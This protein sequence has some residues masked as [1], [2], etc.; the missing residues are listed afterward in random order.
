MPHGL[1]PVRGDVRVPG[2]DFVAGLPTAACWAAPRG[3]TLMRALVGLP[4]WYSLLRSHTDQRRL[5]HVANI[6]V[7]E[8]PRFCVQI[9]RG[10]S[11][12]AT[13]KPRTFYIS[14]FEPHSAR[15]GRWVH[16]RGFHRRQALGLLHASLG[17]IEQLTQLPTR[18]VYNRPTLPRHAAFKASPQFSAKDAVRHRGRDQFTGDL[19]RSYYCSCRGLLRVDPFLSRA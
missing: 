16:A 11:R 6:P 19:V 18:P 14:L 8:M 4:Q 10:G 15:S 13:E 17:R 3:V 5:R 9:Y 2:R 1:C 12:R 7:A